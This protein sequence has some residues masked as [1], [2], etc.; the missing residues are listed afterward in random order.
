M[1]DTAKFIPGRELSRSLAMS[2]LPRL[3]GIFPET[4]LTLALIGPG[5]DVLGFDTHRSMDHDWGPGVTLLVPHDQVETVS[6]SFDEHLD[7]LLPAEICGHPA[8]FSMHPDGT[9]KVDANGT[10]HR[11]RTTS[12]PELLQSTLFI[13]SMREMS[14][15]VWL[16]TPMQTLLELS[17]GEVFVDDS[18]DLTD[19]RRQ[20]RFYPDHIWRYQLAGIWMRIAQVQPFVGRCFETGDILGAATI[21]RG[22]ILDLMRIGLLQSRQ[23]APYAKWLGAAFAKSDN[24]PTIVRVLNDALEHTTDFRSLERSINLVGSAMIGTLNALDLIAEV[25]P[26]PYQFW[27]RPFMVLRAEEVALGLKESIRDYS[28]GQIRATLGG[29]DVISDSTDALGSAEFRLAVRT[30]FDVR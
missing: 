10:G 14:D 22:I 27:D 20:L 29:I 19:L 28:L 1:S 25:D 26:E 17:A 30:M 5:S 2:L 9:S 15:A 7:Q 4:P 24:D 18:G 16:S 11:V 8:R 6:C 21:A 12:V 13:S 3:R 23:Y